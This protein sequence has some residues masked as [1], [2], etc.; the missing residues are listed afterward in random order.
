MNAWEFQMLWE[1]KVLPQ[2]KRLRAT[3]NKATGRTAS[4][5][6]QCQQ[7]LHLHPLELT[8]WN[9]RKNE[10]AS[11]GFSLNPAAVKYYGV[12]GILPISKMISNLTQLTECRNTDY[13]K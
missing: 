7:E 3:L 12:S 9:D 5:S 4:T 1:V 13:G 6:Q 8:I 11:Q 10:D 2:P